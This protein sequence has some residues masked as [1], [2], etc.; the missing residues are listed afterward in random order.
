MQLIRT[1]FDTRSTADDVAAGHDLSGLRAIVTGGAAGIGI[2]T[3]Q[4]LTQAGATVTLAARNGDAARAAAQTIT[5]RTGN[6]AVRVAEIDLAERASV[7]RFVK[8]WTGPLHL[9]INNA[10]IMAGPLSRTREGWELQL[11]TNH[12]GHFALAGGLRHALAAGAAGRH[13]ARI[14]GLSSSAHLRAP[15]NLDDLHFLRRPYDPW[16]AYGQ[17]K[18]AVV[19]FALEASR[20]WASDGIVANAVNPGGIKTG[21]QKHVDPNLQQ[22]WAAAEATGAIRLKTPQQGAA[23][24]LVAALAPEFGS[25]GGHYLNDGN[26]APTVADDADLGYETHA[27]REWA[28]DPDTARALWDA[29][30]PLTTTSR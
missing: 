19:L 25:T 8:E 21:L 22:A 1:K 28:K 10:G 2:E 15:V 26:E 13:G 24:T 20:R 27:V 11:A 18:T 29:S 9:L 17:S 4:A 14:V 5:G 6:A 12:L 3:A 7:E 30:S 23:T 16:I